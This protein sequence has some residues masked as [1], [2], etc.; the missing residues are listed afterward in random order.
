MLDVISII[1]LVLMFS[2]SVLYV[3]GCER[4]KGTHS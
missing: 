1:A 2:L 4:L 3:S